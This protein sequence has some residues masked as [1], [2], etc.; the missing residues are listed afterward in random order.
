ML[1]GMRASPRPFV[2]LLLGAFLAVATL[3]GT[4]ALAADPSPASSAVPGGDSILDRG[5]HCVECYLFWDPTA[6]ARA[7]LDVPVTAD[8]P[9]WLATEL[10]APDGST[11]RLADFAGRPVVVELM[12]TWCASCEDQQQVLLEA[13]ADLPA[14]AVLVSL[15]VDPAGDPG[16]LDDYASARGFD[17]TFVSAPVPLLRTLAET[18]GTTRSIPRRRPSWSSTG[19]APRGCRRSATRT[20]PRSWSSSPAPDSRSTVRAGTHAAVR[21]RA[22]DGTCVWPGLAFRAQQG[23][24]GRGRAAQEQQ[25]AL[26][27]GTRR[28]AAWQGRHPS[29]DLRWSVAAGGAQAALGGSA[30]ASSDSNWLGR[31][32]LRHGSA[33]PGGW[34]A[35]G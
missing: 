32:L 31:P 17:W 4:T 23:R 25:D 33:H 27:G 20:A 1:P 14:D 19:T 15:D 30:R 26:V 22:C 28:P 8:A 3:P 24:P 16:A 13:R 35:S 10:N 7:V 21:A 2:A 6:N 11:V 9:D 18:F 12:A 34:R 5:T 29:G